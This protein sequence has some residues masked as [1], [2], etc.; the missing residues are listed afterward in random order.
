MA[1]ANINST[2]AYL[3][4]IGQ[5]PLLTAEQ[6]ISL[7]R[8]YR[9]NGNLA[10]REKLINCNLR[11]VVSIA[12]SYENEHF[13]LLDLI[14]EGNTGLIQAV[15]K[16]NPD[17]GYRFSTCATPWIK[18]AI[19]KAIQEQGRNIRMPAHIYNLLRKY[20]Q[21]MADFAYNEV[22]NPSEEDIAAAMGV[23]VEKFAELMQWK[24]DTVSLATPLGDESDDTLEDLQADIH[25][26]TPAEKFME[27]SQKSEI[28]RL[29][30]KL[31]ERTSI[32][33]KMRYGLGGPGDPAEFKS[34]H[35]LDEVGKYLGITRE[36]VRQIEKQTLSSLK[37]NKEWRLVSDLKKQD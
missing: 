20:R 4:E 31:P 27:K 23:T 12:K 1:H 9:D 7:A 36:R 35:T 10:A 30:E 11:L 17:L 13:T 34:E 26:P 24:N 32:I 6:E 29:L 25:T 18:Q 16:F 3:K 21:V 37:V 28:Q 33:I 19:S 2:R 22:R 15:E 5:F 14:G 8:E